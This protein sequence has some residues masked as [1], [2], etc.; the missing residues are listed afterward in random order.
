M[1]TFA[2][3]NVKCVFDMQERRHI[4]E[5][6]EMYKK[7]TLKGINKKGIHGKIRTLDGCCPH[8][9]LIENFKDAMSIK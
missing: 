9:S 4:K 6:S 1:I 2:F 3:S 7:K 5:K 8:A